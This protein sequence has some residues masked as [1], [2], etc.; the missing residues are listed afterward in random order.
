MAPS[1]PPRPPSRLAR[2]PKEL[3]KKR[4]ADLI[5][6]IS[7]KDRYAI[8][9][10]PVDVVQV[11][12]Y[13]DLISRPMD[14]STAEKNLQMGVYRTPME[15][16]ADLDL[17][18]SNCCTFNADDSIYFKEAVRLRALAARYYD[19]LVRLLA[20]DGVAAALGLSSA[21]QNGPSAARISQK[22][23]PKH[24]SSAQTSEV[25]IRMTSPFTQ[26]S[27]PNSMDL[28]ADSQSASASASAG[29]LSSF[30]DA[31][32]RRARSNFDAAVAAA[33]TAVVERRQATELAGLENLVSSSDT[34]IFNGPR[35]I[36]RKKQQSKDVPISPRKHPIMVK[37]RLRNSCSEIPVAWQRIGKWHPRGAT[38]SRLLTTNRVSDLLYGHQFQ[39]HVQTSAPMA[40]RLLATILD[41]NVVQQED[42]HRITALQPGV[43][44]RAKEEKTPSSTAA[45]KP[46]IASKNHAE[47]QNGYLDPME[48]D[49]AM[50]SPQIRN[51]DD[52]KSPKRPRAT[53]QFQ[54]SDD[55]DHERF[56]KLLKEAAGS[57]HFSKFSSARVDGLAEST[58]HDISNTSI[59]RLR[60]LLKTKGIDAAFT[61]SIF[62]NYQGNA[63]E[64]RRQRDKLPQEHEFQTYRRNLGELLSSNHE[65]M[66]NILRL[67][68]LRENA[69]EAALENLEDRE[70][71]YVERL[72][73]GMSTAVR[74]FP[75]RYV[76]HPV[77]AAESAMAMAKM[78]NNR[79]PSQ[80]T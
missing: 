5:R 56:K 2:D 65:I 79:Q 63:S 62:D 70:R 50:V 19:D 9:L 78:I 27:E 35:A 77:D 29:N 12:G 4:G 22:R 3:L 72:A 59:Y 31:H 23:P 49:V 37:P 80:R 10:E 17:I 30:R 53:L 74:S 26:N 14:L 33:S 64:S 21:R 18:W 11:E 20:K 69:D 16:R 44:S 66:L 45:P 42:L 48:T 75:P 68:A 41:P 36:L 58:R 15:L 6:K 51:E 76:V 73:D 57:E 43:A 52:A 32:L 28:D 24:R 13:A 8:F 7:D 61:N 34:Q 40:R 67:R 54:R 46:P 25:Q 60:A 47:L 55:S 1:R 71:E 39:K 38:A